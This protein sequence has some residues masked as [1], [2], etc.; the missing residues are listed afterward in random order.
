MI[1]EINN[2]INEKWDLLWENI[3]SL[4]I[5]ISEFII[6]ERESFLHFIIEAQSNSSIVYNISD[7]DN[8]SFTMNEISK[9][10]FDKIPHLDI[11]LS[12][13]PE[14]IDLSNF[15]SLRYLHIHGKNYETCVNI[16]YKLCNLLKEFWI[17]KVD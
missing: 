4:K 2:E 3:I 8:F 17:F 6:G 10:S 15:T 12:N 14:I 1:I 16:P 11:S 7:G 9:Y 13:Q 5:I